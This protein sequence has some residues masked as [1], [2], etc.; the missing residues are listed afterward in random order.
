[1]K[2]KG[3]QRTVMVTGLLVL[4]GSLALAANDRYTLTGANGI[5]FAEFRG[6]ETW[7]S[8]APSQPSD[9]LKVITGNALMIEAYKAGFPAN[10]KPVPDGAMMAKMEWSKKK[11]PDFPSILVPDTLRRIGFMVKDSK[12]FPDTDGWGYA[13]WVYE[14]A[15]DTF[16]PESADPG[17]GKTVCHQCHTIV[18]GKDFVFTAYPFR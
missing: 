1:M 14:S 15:S 16:K 9:G 11:G 8:I 12:R 18:K 3:T 13:Q 17:F 4:L 5:A 6:Y 10:G 2:S 7:Q